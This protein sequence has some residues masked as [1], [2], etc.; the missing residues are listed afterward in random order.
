MLRKVE[1]KGFIARRPL[2]RRHTFYIPCNILLQSD[3]DT[4]L[5]YRTIGYNVCPLMTIDEAEL[6]VKRKPYLVRLLHKY[7][8][9]SILIICE[10]LKD[11]ENIKDIIGLF[12]II[13]ILLRDSPREPIEGVEM[14]KYYHMYNPDEYVDGLVICVEL[15]ERYGKSIRKVDYRIIHS[16]LIRKLNILKSR[17]GVCNIIVDILDK[18]YL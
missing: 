7:S 6:L 14:Y 15:F 3:V 4:I 5:K 13:S 8:I 11:I 1:L 9:S 10:R 18:A 16:V 2:N 17:K 12:K